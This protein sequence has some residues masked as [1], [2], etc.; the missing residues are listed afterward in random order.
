MHLLSETPIETLA[1]DPFSVQPVGAGPFVLTSWNAESATL[2]PASAADVPAIDPGASP[3]PGDGPAPV[4]TASPT[5]PPSASPAASVAVGA[6]ASPGASV[7]ASAKLKPSAAASTEPSPVATATPAPTARPEPALPGIAMYFYPDAAS[8]A[9]A[10]R[11]G[12]LDAA[13]GLPPDLAGQL[14]ALP[15]NRLLSYPRTT[16][17]AVALNLRPGNSEL[18]LPAV[19]HGLLAAIDR[20]KLIAAVF[21]GAATRADSV[22]PP[23][24]WA[25][26]PKVSRLVRYDVQRAA[27]NFKAGG[28]KRLAGGWAA[29]GAK[30]PY[31]MELISPDA[32]SN[33]TAMAVAEAVAADWRAFGLQTV[34]TGLPPAQF[35]EDRLRKGKF[36]SAAIDVSI[37]LDPDLYPLF[38][39]T[40][41]TGAGSNISGIQD[42]ALD[43]DLI[44]ARAPGS[45]TARRAAYSKLQQRLAERTYIL[46]IA[47]RNELVVVSGRLQGPVVRELGDPSDRYWDVL[48]WRLADGG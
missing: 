41:A 40:Q 3:A 6:S 4:A 27:A 42:V 30:K 23:S 19:R 31:V 5:E 39:S 15:G 21:G 17:T 26:D 9:A 34:V 2:I 29:P 44:R 10:Y 43:R 11:A 1:D 45:E 48:T 13:A 7:G 38:A 28:W 32:E 35:V 24:S 18:R 46:P 14:A 20:A 22:I 47:F 16:L 8:L 33:P 36:Q 25:F 37:G 12:G